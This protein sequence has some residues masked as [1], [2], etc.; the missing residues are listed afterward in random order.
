MPK[1]K[2]TKTYVDR[3]APAP[4]DVIHWDI[5]LP[6]FGVRVKPSGV[7]SYVCQY[8]NR[9]T[10]ESRRMTLGKHGPLLTFHQAKLEAR[11]VLGDAIGGGD[12]ARDRQEK[13]K[14]PTVAQLTVEY[15]DRHA[16]PKKRPQSVRHDRGLISKYVLPHF[17]NKKV[18]SVSRRDITVLHASLK[19]R[20][21][22][23]NRL[24]AL[25]S[26]MF[27]LSVDWGWRADNPAKGV[28]RY[29]EYRRERW[30]SDEELARLLR[31]LSEHPNR[32]ASD[33]VRMQLL[34]GAR[35]GEVLNAEWRDI[36]FDRG[37]WIKPSHHTKQKR[38][39]YVPLSGQALAL[40]QSMRRDADPDVPFLFPG[41]V[42]GK[43]LTELKK[44]W[45]S[46]QR[47]ANLEGYR[48]H[49]NR[50]THASHLVSSGLSLEIV[51]RLLGHTTPTTTKRYAHLADAPL[52]AAAEH[53]ASKL[54]ALS[55]TQPE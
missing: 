52:R 10:G 38:T 15:M 6:G 46:V 41:E 35:I 54:D 23:A 34:T 42:P 21:Y 25:L 47:E 33:A 8:R 18:E 22:Q 5:D 17:G 13:R 3:I 11:R 30:L 2:L 19:D 53:F 37:V 12:M 45:R 29:V 43:P 24:L 44:F 48:L 31:V 36:H 16:I 50:H 9:E 32:R 28:P 1:A 40:L 7:R 20:P 51:G 49:D 4:A 55:R 14:A 39:E 26:K 27:S